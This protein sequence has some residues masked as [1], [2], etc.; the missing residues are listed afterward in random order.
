MHMRAL[1]RSLTPLPDE[2]LHGYLLR[3][4]YRIDHTP[5]DLARMAGWQTSGTLSPGLLLDL[6]RTHAQGLAHLARLTEHE[7]MAMTLAP[8]R[9]NCPPIAASLTSPH[10]R[11]RTDPWITVPE[12]RYCPTCLAGD[13][14]EIQN[15]YG[16]AW[17]LQWHLPVLFACPQHQRFLH[18]TCPAC[19]H[20]AAPAFRPPAASLFRRRN[21]ASRSLTAM[22]YAA[23]AWTTRRACIPRPPPR[24]STSM[25]DSKS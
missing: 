13:G 18:H 20:L 16:G 10:Q 5:M 21:A 23:N 25:P 1:P 17:K 9:E 7:V 6:P 24:S 8:M 22:R 14:T 15:R 2:A 12:A 4:S 11:L 3:L 19:G